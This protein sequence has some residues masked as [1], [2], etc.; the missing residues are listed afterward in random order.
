MKG[1]RLA[2]SVRNLLNEH[3]ALADDV[4]A[5]SLHNHSTSAILI[6]MTAEQNHPPELHLHGQPLGALLQHILHLHLPLPQFH[7]P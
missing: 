3:L 5:A 2:V 6:L 1:Q 4:D 7:H